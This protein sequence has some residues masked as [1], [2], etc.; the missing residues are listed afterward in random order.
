MKATLSKSKKNGFRLTLISVFVFGAA[1]FIFLQN[2]KSNGARLASAETKPAETPNIRSKSATRSIQENWRGAP[3]GDGED[4]I[5]SYH[6]Y[7]H[8]PP[9][10]DPRDVVLRQYTVHRCPNN[11]IG[12]MVSGQD[13]R[14]YELQP[15]RNKEFKE[16]NPKFLCD[17]DKITESEDQPCVVYSFGSWDEIS[18]EVFII[19][20]KIKLSPVLFLVLT[21]SRLTLFSH[22]WFGLFRWALTRSQNR[23]AMCIPL[24]HPNIQVNPWPINI[25]LRSTKWE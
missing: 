5:D 15:P 2:E 6:S 19:H 18:F 1:L 9:G 17:I 20:R 13:S 22:F 10:N 11:G 16:R 3:V 23:N 25:I 12:T 21:N 14:Y 24:I 4:T 8:R 7:D